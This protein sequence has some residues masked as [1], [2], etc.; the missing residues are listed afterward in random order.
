MESA[1]PEILL[2]DDDPIIL[3]ILTL[4]LD[5]AGYRSAVAE[6]GEQALH[7]LQQHPERFSAII[8]DRVMPK[9]SGIDLL[10]KVRV[11]PQF[12]KLPIIMLTGHAER[13]DVGAAVIAGV[14]DFLYKPIDKDLLLLVIKRALRDKQ[15]I[16]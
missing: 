11:L 16:F 2:V 6:N 14:Y 10:H 5:E 7:L 1:G 9:L 8:L 12:R 3:K 4:Y 13:E 15:Q